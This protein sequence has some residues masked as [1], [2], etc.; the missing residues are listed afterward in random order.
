ML[1]RVELFYTLVA[2]IDSESRRCLRG[3]GGHMHVVCMQG[4]SAMAWL[5][6]RGGHQ[7]PARK[8][9]PAATSL[10]GVVARGQPARGCCPRLALPPAGAVTP[11]A[12]RLLAVKGSRR[13]PKGNDEGSAVRVKEG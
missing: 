13:P 4:R 11:V 1:N 5:P 6:A 12:G 2:E 7:R 8:G 10:Q 9:Q 3:R